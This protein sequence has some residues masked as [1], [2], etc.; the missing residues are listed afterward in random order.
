MSK[1][2]PVTQ[3][4][5]SSQNIPDWL[6]SLAQQAGGQGANL[7]QYTPYTGAN[8]QANLTPAQLQAI[9]M[10]QSNAGGA[11]GII[12]Q[13]V[14]AANAL[15]GFNAG[16]VNAQTLGSQVQGLLNPATQNVIDTTNA[17]LD[18]NTTQAQNGLDGQLAAQ[19][20]F[21]GDRQ[22]IAD[23]TVQ[24]QGNMTKAATDAS[25]NQ[26]NYNTALSTALSAGQGNQN[27]AIG[28]AG[29]QLGG[30]NALNSLGQGMSGVNAQDINGLM[31]TG[32]T[33][34]A[35]Q[36]GQNAFDY[37]K[38]MNGYQ[39]PDQQ[40]STFAGILGSLPHDTTG[41]QTTTGNVY[42]NGLLGAL[43]LGTSIAGLGMGG[44]KTLGGSAIS[45]LLGMFSD[46]RLKEDIERVGTL[47]DGT[48]VY[49]YRYKGTLPIHL[50]LMADEV[51]QYA[52]EAI[53]LVQGHKVVEYGAATA[54]ARALYEG[55]H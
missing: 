8:V 21:G 38:Y 50:G 40:A 19:H 55:V 30:V 10:S 4:Q 6:S 24:N 54:R 28:S 35:T 33:Q 13:G 12:G 39:I 44:G 42:S 52:P 31:G 53:G 34:Q 11:G 22:A 14:P 16:Q 7:P 43:G 48:P 25:L 9:Q 17:Q 1:S 51:E 49:R 41:N 36:S 2:Q 18:K 32:G 46:R 27:A 5:N 45:G 20:A 47:F 23:A 29:I 15:T 37:Q 26:G 3:T